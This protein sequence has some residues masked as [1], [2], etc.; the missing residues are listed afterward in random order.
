ME[1]FTQ[2]IIC[3]ILYSTKVES[4][5]PQ[6]DG[7]EYLLGATNIESDTHDIFG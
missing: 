1:F 4:L 3:M 2:T 6:K 7:V 5:L